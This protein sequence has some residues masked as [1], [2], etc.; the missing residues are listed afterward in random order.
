MQCP[1]CGTENEED[2]TYCKNCGAPLQEKNPESNTEPYKKEI[3]LSAEKNEVPI[4]LGEMIVSILI[5][6]AAGGIIPAVFFPGIGGVCCLW[7][8]LIGGVAVLLSKHFNG[9]K[10]KIPTSKAVVAGVLAGLI[11]AVIIVGNATL[12]LQK[13]DFS[14]FEEIMEESEES[15][16]DEKIEPE[17]EITDEEIEE[18]LD[19]FSSLITATLLGLSFFSVVVYPIFGAL[20]GIIANEIT[21]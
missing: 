7:A 12:E 2:N 16:L 8:G 6:G 5:C 4:T 14:E 21:K 20:G 18:M 15:G 1:Q 19:G 10:S 9:I 3:I 13:M 11:A 17:H